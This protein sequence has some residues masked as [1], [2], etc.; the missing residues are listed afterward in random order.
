MA[1]ASAAI[2]TNNGPLAF[3]DLGILAHLTNPTING[4]NHNVVEIATKNAT[5][6]K[7]KDSATMTPMQWQI[8][9]TCDT[10]IKWRPV[11]ARLIPLMT[12]SRGFSFFAALCKVIGVETFGLAVRGLRDMFGVPLL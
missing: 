5:E 11:P 1:N 9:A 3:V 10:K 2:E 4:T 6:P 7:L 12:V 8:V